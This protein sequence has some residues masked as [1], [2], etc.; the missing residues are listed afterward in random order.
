MIEAAIVVG[1]A[2]TAWVLL[3]APVR[4]NYVVLV[5]VLA[6]VPPLAHVPN[7]LVSQLFITRVLV[8][9]AAL[10]LAIRVRR[11]EA[12][13]ARFGGHPVFVLVALGLVV[14]LVNGVLFVHDIGNL[15]SAFQRWMLLL[16]QGLVLLVVCALL[17]AIDD[18]VWA[19]KVIVLAFG[20]AALVGLFE[21]VT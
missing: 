9:V 11:G 17:R 8:V 14:A 5:L 13:G 6:L 12:P 10:G 20:A 19:T 18:L 21:S 15:P 16:D 4:T 2:V 3:T 7:G 1:T